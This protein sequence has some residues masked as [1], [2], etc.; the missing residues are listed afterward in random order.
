MECMVCSFYH[1]TSLLCNLIGTWKFLSGGPR[2][3][4]KFTRP[5]SH[6]ELG[7]GKRL[8]SNRRLHKLAVKYAHGNILTHVANHAHMWPA[9]LP[10]F[11][12]Q[13]WNCG[14]GLGTRLYTTQY[15]QH[16]RKYW[17]RCIVT[18][19]VW[20]RLLAHTS[21]KPSL[22]QLCKHEGLLFEMN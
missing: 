15:Q 13:H 6:R 14:S 18:A 3:L 20:H 1:M 5:F 4:P 8:W 12:V 17:R 7:L 16:V 9:R 19:S 10:F 2:T 11:C 22:G 21:N